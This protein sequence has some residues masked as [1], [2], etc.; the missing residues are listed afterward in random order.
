MTKTLVIYYSILRGYHPIYSWIWGP[1]NCLVGSQS[2][3]SKCSLYGGSAPYRPLPG[4]N[5]VITPIARVITYNPS[6]TFFS[7]KECRVSYAPTP[8]LKTGFWAR[9]VCIVSPYIDLAQVYVQLGGTSRDCVLVWRWNQSRCRRILKC[10]GPNMDQF[11]IEKQGTI[12]GAME[13]QLILRHTHTPKFWK[14]MCF[15]VFEQH[16]ALKVKQI[17]NS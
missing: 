6:C 17:I 3:P 8:H 1:P 16:F 12:W 11:L 9:L 4:A 15:L 5:E 10:R 13:G 14:V 2:A 7:A